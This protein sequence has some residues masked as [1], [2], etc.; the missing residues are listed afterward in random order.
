MARGAADNTGAAAQDTAG[1]SLFGRK[2]H[3]YGLWF[4]T[5]LRKSGRP[6][7]LVGDS[8]EDLESLL[9]KRRS[10]PVEEVT[11]SKGGQVTWR[12]YYRVVY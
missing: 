2:S 7:I 1:P 9:A 10:E 12:L 8:A 11:G 5:S 4:P 3:M 6:L